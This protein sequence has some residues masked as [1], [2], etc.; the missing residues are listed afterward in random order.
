MIFA[1]PVPH[2]RSM[3]LSALQLLTGVFL[4]TGCSSSQPMTAQ[5]SPTTI[6][7]VR[8]AEKLD[9][10]DPES[11]LSPAGEAR[12]DALANRLRDEGVERIYATIKARTQQTVAPLAVERDLEIIALL[13]DAIED[14]VQ[15]IQADDVG[16]VVVVCGHSNTVPAIVRALSG[17]QVDGLSEEQYD[18]LFKVEIPPD[19]EPRVEVLRYGEPTP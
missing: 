17:I 10:S 16:K 7:V 15:F 13:P 19:G 1:R 6:Y 14:L 18:R 2:L 3:Q 11:L 4:L 5:N 12:A 8:H 9:A